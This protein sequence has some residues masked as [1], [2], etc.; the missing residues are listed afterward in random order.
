MELF[1]GHLPSRPL[2]LPLS[3][4][5]GIPF[6]S[7][8]RVE[9]ELGNILTCLFGEMEMSGLDPGPFRRKGEMN[10]CSPRRQDDRRVF[11]G[12]VSVQA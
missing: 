10:G 7:R 11:I 1:A 6:C 4:E 8:G 3:S 2:L 9:G 12:C 5:R